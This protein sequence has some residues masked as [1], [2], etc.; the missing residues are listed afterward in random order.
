[1]S[2]IIGV[3][4]K[5]GTGKTTLAGLIVQWL[6][7]EKHSSI[8]AIDADPNANL[9]EKLGFQE[10]E[11]VVQVIDEFAGGR[12]DI[13]SGVSKDRFLE[14]KIQELVNEADGFDLV[15]MGRPEGAG[16]YCYAN[17]VLRALIEKLTK[18]YAYTVI[19]NEAGMEHL[20][21]RTTRLIDLLFIISDE[22]R[23]GM[24]S[25]KRIYDLTKELDIRI[26]KAYLIINRARGGSSDTHDEINKMGIELAGSIP[27][28]DELY[29]FGVEGKPVTE[30]GEQSTARRAIGGICKA[31]IDGI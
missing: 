16:C 10:A 15:S 18:S 14:Y 26:G 31:L 12:K 20:S 11:G 21:R 30:L 7:K 28:D 4:G 25:A 17:N 27:E 29:R 6:A 3:A 1:M 9:A 8:L 5:G 19:D 2:T 22:T 24:R 23:V 13:P